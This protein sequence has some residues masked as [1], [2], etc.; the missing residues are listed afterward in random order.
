MAAYMGCDLRKLNFINAVILVQDMLE[1]MLPVEGNHRHSVLVQKEKT[2]IAVDHR[3]LIWS[4]PVIY[5]P[6][7][8]IHNLLA[9]RNISF[10]TLGFRIFDDIFHITLA[11][12]LMI[13]TNPLFLE[14]NIRQSQ[15]AELRDPQ[16]RIEQ[17]INS[18][19]ILAVAVVFL[20]KFQE[21]PFLCTG[22][23]FSGHAVIDN[24]RCQFKPK[25][26]FSYCYGARLRTRYSAGNDD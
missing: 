23:G 8:T 17:N 12:E 15:A 26:I 7:E 4:F 21:C 16:S 22:D 1:I 13:H 25:R 9:H 14:I 24:Y 11:L 6:P 10:T 3:L 18:I 19:V 2:G 20:D 5:D